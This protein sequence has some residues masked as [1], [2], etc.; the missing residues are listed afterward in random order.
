MFSDITK[1]VNPASQFVST[2]FELAPDGV[3]VLLVPLL[4][5]TELLLLVRLVLDHVFVP[6]ARHV[7]NLPVPDLALPAPGLRVPLQPVAD[8]QLPLYGGPLRAHVCVGLPGRHLLL[9]LLLPRNWLQAGLKLPLVL[10]VVL[11]IRQP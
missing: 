4:L 10:H 6:R 5:A 7:V 1:T 11:I 2:N 9:P 8:A 3:Y